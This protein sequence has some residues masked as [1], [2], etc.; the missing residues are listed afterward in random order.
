MHCDTNTSFTY[1]HASFFKFYLLK[2]TDGK[3]LHIIK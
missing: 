3:Y 2:S 1:V